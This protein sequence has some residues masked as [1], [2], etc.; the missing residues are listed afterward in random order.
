MA[1]NVF[2]KLDGVTGG[3]EDPRH[4]GEI[5]VSS[6]SWGQPHPGSTASVGKVQTPSVSLTAPAETAS[7]FLL[8]YSKEGRNF[9]QATLTVEQRSERGTM[10]RALLVTMSSVQIKSASYSGGAWDDKDGVDTMTLDF[11]NY[12]LSR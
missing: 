4:R 3:S 12:K 6:Y 10:F 11:E 5:E 8:V 1:N 9:K 7:P 2:L